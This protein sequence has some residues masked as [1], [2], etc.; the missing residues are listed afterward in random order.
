MNNFDKVKQ[1][2]DEILKYHGKNIL[3]KKLKQ[4]PL[5]NELTN[6]L[7]DDWSLNRKLFHLKNNIN[8]CPKC[9]ICNN[10]VNFNSFDKGYNLYCSI[11][12]AFKD[13]IVIEKANISRL[14]NFNSKEDL[15]LHM[16]NLNIK[17]NEKLK[18]LSR[19]TE[20]VTNKNNNISNALKERGGYKNSNNPMFGKA[21][22]DETK[23]K[24]KESAKIRDNSNI[25]KYKRTEQHKETL[26][27]Q[28]T[29]NI[30]S[31]KLKKSFNTK[32][33][34]IL[35]K[36]LEDLN[37]LYEQ[38]FLIQFRKTKYS[39][40]RHCYDFYICN[41]NIL[42]EVDGDYWHSLENIKIR[43]IECN[44]IA[45]KF[46]F[47]VIRFTEFQLKHKEKEVM[48]EIFIYIKNLFIL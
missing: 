11:K 21:H 5:F 10:N 12:C 22:S 1:L 31:G 43:D 33:E 45:D 41:T 34:L 39:N 32:P 25:G 8:K 24:M 6:H 9:K 13:P 20:W 42:I 38:Q 29:K 14:S 36:I 17:G 19:D 30:K 27:I 37:I 4:I 47:N 44:K 7:P 46:G 48:E 28:I 3:Y 35:K 26:S 18:E 15:I 16:K 2:I 23:I 40:W